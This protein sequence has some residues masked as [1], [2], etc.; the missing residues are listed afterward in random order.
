VASLVAVAALPF[1]FARRFDEALLLA[2]KLPSCFGCLAFLAADLA[3]RAHA[4]IVVIVVTG[5]HLATTLQARRAATQQTV[6]RPVPRSGSAGRPTTVLMRVVRAILT[7]AGHHA[8]RSQSNGPKAA[9]VGHCG[10]L[11]RS[12]DAQ[13]R[14]GAHRQ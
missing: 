1:G 6:F 3:R 7:C 9:T 11:P 14:Y 8:C 13:P 12:G 5:C 10:G 4:L 2:L